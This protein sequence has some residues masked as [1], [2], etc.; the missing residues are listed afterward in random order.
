M[1][2]EKHEQDIKLQNLHRQA[3]GQEQQP[4]QSQHARRDG[5]NGAK[6]QPVTNARAFSVALKFI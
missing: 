3:A 2:C 5:N 4:D 1:H 6:H